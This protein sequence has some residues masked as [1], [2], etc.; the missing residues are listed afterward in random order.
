[1]TL[2]KISTK[3]Y[4]SDEIIS[5]LEFLISK[6]DLLNTKNIEDEDDEDEW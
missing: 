1:L 5:A 2:K 4:S 6:Y 3:L